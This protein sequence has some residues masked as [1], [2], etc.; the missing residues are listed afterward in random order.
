MLQQAISLIF[1]SEV[2]KTKD[3]DLYGNPDP[4]KLMT[5]ELIFELM[6]DFNLNGWTVQPIVDKLPAKVSYE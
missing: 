1:K 4:L 5:P 3:I 6:E 2:Y